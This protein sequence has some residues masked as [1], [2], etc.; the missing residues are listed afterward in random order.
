MP[1]LVLPVYLDT[2]NK[3]QKQVYRTVDPSLATPL[4]LLAHRRNEAS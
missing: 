3:I 4:E 2:L 1:G